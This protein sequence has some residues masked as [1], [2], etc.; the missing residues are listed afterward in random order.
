MP[1]VNLAGDETWTEIK[2][3]ASGNEDGMLDSQDDEIFGIKISGPSQIVGGPKEARFTYGVGVLR[4]QGMHTYTHT[5]THT[6]T[7]Q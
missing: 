1:C 4:K 5:H 3:A 7:Q 6:H 2:G